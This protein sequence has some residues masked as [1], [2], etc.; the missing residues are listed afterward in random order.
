M[1]VSTTSM[2]ET[3][4]VSNDDQVRTGDEVNPSTVADVVDRLVRL[5]ATPDKD[6]GDAAA[7]TLEFALQATGASHGLVGSIDAENGDLV[8][9]RHTGLMA[10]DSSD[11]AA[12]GLRL[13]LGSHGH[14]TGLWQHC[15]AAR[16]PFLTNDAK[17]HPAARGLPTG[18][19]DVTSFLAA[20]A[21][22]G[23]LPLGMIAL[24][25]RPGGFVERHL[26][27]VARL[28]E[29]FGLAVQ[30]TRYLAALRRNE[31]QYRGFFDAFTDMMLVL[32]ERGRIR[33]VNPAGVALT[34]FAKD[35]LIDHEASLLLRQDQR[36]V[37]ETVRQEAVACGATEWKTVLVAKGG[38]ERTCEVRAQ[39][40]SG[41]KV[42][43]LSAHDITERLAT[44]SALQTERLRLRQLVNNA[45]III[46]G[47][48]GD[49]HL[50]SL[51]PA[52]LRLVG[53][54]AGDVAGT[55]CADL[56]GFAPDVAKPLIDRVWRGEHAD[57]ESTVIDLF[58]RTRNLAWS[59][60]PRRRASGAVEEV[61]AFGMDISDRAE[62]ENRATGQRERLRAVLNAI[63]DFVFFKDAAGTYQDC[64][65]AFAAFVGRPESEIVDR[66]DADLFPVD[67]AKAFRADDQRVMRRRSAE[68]IEEWVD[69]P[70]GRRALVETI[71]Q[72]LFGTGEECTGLVGISRDVTDRW[73]VAEGLGKREAIFGAVVRAARGFLGG[74]AWDSY[75]PAF[76]AELGKA[77]DA[78][79]T[80]IL[81]NDVAEGG[82]HSPRTR[83][84]WTAVGAPSPWLAADRSYAEL[85]LSAWEE[86]LS[87]ARTITGRVASR[88][89]SA[90][91]ALADAEIGSFVAA[92]VFVADQWWGV[93]L[94]T[95]TEPRIWLPD[96]IEALEIASAAIGSAVVRE[97]AVRAVV[98]AKDE[99]VTANRA[100]SVF[101]ANLSHEIRTPLHGILSY[102]R[103]GTKKYATASPERLREYFETITVSGV[104]LLDLLTGLLEMSKLDAGRVSFEMRELDITTVL[105]ALSSEMNVRLAERGM[106]LEVEP[107]AVSPVAYFDERA[108]S[109]V[110]SNL[111][112][113]AARYGKSD[114]ATRVS[115]H[116]RRDRAGRSWLEIRVADRGMGVPEGERESIFGEF[117]QSSRTSSGAG[118]TGLGLAICRRIVR[119]HEGQIWYEP[120]PDGTGSIFCFTLPRHSQAVTPRSEEERGHET[121]EYDPGR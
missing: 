103:F 12:D 71:K 13:R 35:E 66:R 77:V 45:P 94:V 30:R 33:A 11:G 109:Q 14:A 79:H 112:N 70:D 84:A 64:N 7:V 105:K 4:A 32:D 41:Q 10:P 28:A 67:A 47:I 107:I 44:R 19:G 54:P 22:Y 72:P 23:D 6:V 58:G 85:G 36:A 24:A 89:E 37:F 61:W 81:I 91:T 114:T 65:P 55:P 76:L 86:E 97:R 34:G 80:Y 104:R 53:L 21:M 88:A 52:G 120:Q 62:A 102:A 111:V 98:A 121:H 95:D 96:E 93:L 82:L 87:R 15:L 9:H 78:S 3:L 69:Y 49:G 117:V 92:P 119:Q 59:F 63:P 38:E 60:V 16:Q 29:V 43:F 26:G 100:K 90:S 113:N 75:I 73:R 8:V 2:W 39:F 31:E 40:V 5:L 118:G 42:L 27:L 115:L 18:H 20:P 83:D 50:T 116:D 25:N 68:R 56:L 46:G 51:N 48:D 108:I 17:H 110:L 106:W 99:A 101:L 74:T 1:T 57:G